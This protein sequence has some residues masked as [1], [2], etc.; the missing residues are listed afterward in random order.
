MEE[1][2][3]NERKIAAIGRIEAAINLDL[4]RITASAG[5]RRGKSSIIF[6]FR[7]HRY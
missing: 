2:V 7:D 4:P 3:A 6:K 5:V 1:W